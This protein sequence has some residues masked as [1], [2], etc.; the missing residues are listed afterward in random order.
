ARGRGG[1]GKGAGGPQPV[2]RAAL[3]AR[4]VVPDDAEVVER[5]VSEVRAAGAFADGPDIR[6]GRPQPFVH[7]DVAEVVDVNADLFEPDAGSVWDAPD[8]DQDVARLDRALT[9]GRLYRH[10]DLLAALSA[11]RERLCGGE[12]RHALVA[13]H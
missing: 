4:H 6:C 3:A 11:N 10:G 12:K 8:G 13:E 5:D 7:A 2:G 9:G 1:G